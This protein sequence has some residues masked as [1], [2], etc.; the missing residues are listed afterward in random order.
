MSA[1]GVELVGLGTAQGVGVEEMRAG[2]QPVIGTT[3]VYQEPGVYTLEASALLLPFAGPVLICELHC[4]SKD[5]V[6]LPD[7]TGSYLHN[8]SVREP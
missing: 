4:L 7:T 1:T 6:K 2:D 8:S 5:P 3:S